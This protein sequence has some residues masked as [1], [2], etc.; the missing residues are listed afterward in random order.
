MQDLSGKVEA[1]ESQQEEIERLSQGIGRLYLTAQT[2][3]ES[4]LADAEQL[5]GQDVYKRQR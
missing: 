3:V 2:N 1:F 4:M 5:T